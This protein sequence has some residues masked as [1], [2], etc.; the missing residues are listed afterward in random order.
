MAR[1]RCDHTGLNYKL[2]KRNKHE[3]GNDEFCGQEEKFEHV[4]LECGKCKQIVKFQKNRVQLR[5]KEILQMNTGRYLG[6]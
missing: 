1:E 2:K 3:T 6:F 4:M 5:L